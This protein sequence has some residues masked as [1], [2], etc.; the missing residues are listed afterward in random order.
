M[1]LSIETVKLISGERMGGGEGEEVQ[2]HRPRRKWPAV[3]GFAGAVA[4]LFALVRG[5]ITALHSKAAQASW[6]SLSEESSASSSTSLS[7]VAANEYSSA[8][9]VDDYPS[10]EGK[11]L[12]EPHR[13]TT[14]TALGALTEKGGTFTWEVAR[15]AQND[16]GSTSEQ[17][18]LVESGLQVSY[19][20]TSLG[21]YDISL[22]V[23]RFGLK[24]EVVKKTAKCRYVR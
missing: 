8:P 12:V 20:F 2:E 24:S 13:T 11:L 18:L 19:I 1:S 22:S 17:V 5:D 16:D 15:I 7:I 3:V 4:A 21:T 9:S 14:L 10:L 6:D 23:S